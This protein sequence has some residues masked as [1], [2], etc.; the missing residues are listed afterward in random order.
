MLKPIALATLISGTLDI[1][2]AMGLTLIYG[3]EIPNMLRYVASGPFPSAKDMGAS[4]ATLGLL[5]H[6]TLMAIMAAVFMVAA[7]ARPTILEKPIETAIAYG[8]LTYVVLDLLVVPLRFPAAF[9]P[10]P[11]S[12]ATQLFAHVV[13]VGFVFVAIARRYFQARTRI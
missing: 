11:M 4:G 13:L 10:K 5:V 9:P 1:L 2:L 3:R 6:F 12:I 7:R 8:V